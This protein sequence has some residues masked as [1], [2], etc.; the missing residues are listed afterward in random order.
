MSMQLFD[1]QGRRALVTGSSQGIGLSL[2]SG[3]AAAGADVVLN[4]RDI[5]K[6]DAAVEKLRGTGA[7]ANG[8]SFDVT[9]PEAVKDA[10]DRV[11]SELGPVDVLVNNAGIQRRRPLEEFD[12]ET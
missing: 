12:F 6:L 1:L 10:V 8:V 5:S 3:L 11:E 4:G 7:T 9:E 2:A